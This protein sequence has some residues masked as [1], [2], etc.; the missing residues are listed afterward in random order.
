MRIALSLAVV[1]KDISPI[2]FTGSSV[3]TGAFIFNTKWPE[4]LE[5]D[6]LSRRWNDSDS[7]E[8]PLKNK[9]ENPYFVF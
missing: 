1:E 4:R 7:P 2:I 5:R 9:A 3:T 8:N 6:A